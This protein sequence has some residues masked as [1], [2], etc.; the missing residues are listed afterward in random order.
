MA[1]NWKKLNMAYDAIQQQIKLTSDQKLVEHF[2]YVLCFIE[3]DRRQSVM[4]GIERA[5]V[6]GVSILDPEFVVT[7][8]N[9]TNVSGDIQKLLFGED[10]VLADAIRIYFEEN[11]GGWLHLD[12]AENVVT[13]GNLK[14]TYSDLVK[15]YEQ[16]AEEWEDVLSVLELLAPVKRY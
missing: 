5:D 11:S 1:Q 4:D 16:Q 12:K 8:D 13:T 3:G 2:E 7:W 10:I 14:E 9:L 15:Y 6:Y